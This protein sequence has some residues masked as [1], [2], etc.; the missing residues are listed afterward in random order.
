MPLLSTAVAATTPQDWLGSNY[1][2][3]ADDCDRV[4]GLANT[5]ADII[6]AIEE[7]ANHYG[8]DLATFRPSVTFAADG[9]I[10]VDLGAPNA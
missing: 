3:L 10:I 2:K 9:T 6:E 5:I 4:P 7:Q 1:P 8:L